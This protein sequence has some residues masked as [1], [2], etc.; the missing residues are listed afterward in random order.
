MP[1]YTETKTLLACFRLNLPPR[2]F[3]VLVMP[4]GLYQNFTK[5]LFTNT[6]MHK[7][8]TWSWS[9][10]Q[11]PLAPSLLQGEWQSL[12]PFHNSQ[13]PSSLYPRKTIRLASSDHPTQS[14]KLFRVSSKTCNYGNVMSSSSIVFLW[15]IIW[16][17]K[18]LCS[19]YE[20]FCLEC[21]C[22]WHCIILR[23]SLLDM[24]VHNTG[25]IWAVQ[26]PQTW[27]LKAFS[28]YRH[29]TPSMWNHPQFETE[30]QQLN[31]PRCN[32]SES[33]HGK[34]LSL[35]PEVQHP[36]VFGFLK[37]YQYYFPRK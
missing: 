27:G 17:Q 15:K 36:M 18:L 32:S 7:R 9:S 12:R 1:L 28:P 11:F 2:K 8:H 19:P 13:P 4:S 30:F 21:M 14:A 16:I 31:V 20:S 29:Y 5:L 34:W 10:F 33:N 37:T 22:P 6:R 25:L 23:A 26:N 35:S 3:L 24:F